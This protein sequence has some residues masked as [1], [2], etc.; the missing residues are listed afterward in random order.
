MVHVGK[1]RRVGLAHSF[2]HHYR[3]QSRER[4]TATLLASAGDH[5]LSRR[6]QDSL[7]VGERAVSG[8]VEEHVVSLRTS[9]EILLRVVE[10]HVR[11][12]PA[13]EFEVLRARH[14]GDVRSE[15]LGDLHRERP[16]TAAR[17]VDDDPLAR[18]NVARVPQ[19][20]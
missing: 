15:R 6:S 11:V 8:H 1:E 18:L 17:A 5:N 14:R 7:A 3:Q 19:A 12:Q 13:N 20:L 2:A 16:D 10:Q 4:A 9:S